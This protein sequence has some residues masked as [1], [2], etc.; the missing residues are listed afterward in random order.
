[1]EIIETNV[2]NIFGGAN[3]HNPNEIN[4]F[5]GC[6]F[7]CSYCYVEGNNDKSSKLYVKMNAAKLV[8]RD[9]GNCNPRI[10]I[11]LSSQTDP[12]L[13]AEKKYRHCC[14]VNFHNNVI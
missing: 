6:M 8:E 9:I 13:Y 14:P 11:F 5:I 10:A 1:M 12:Y 2:N 3:T 4:P 7:N